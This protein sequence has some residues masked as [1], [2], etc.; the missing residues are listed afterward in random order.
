MEKKG[1]LLLVDCGNSFVFR[2]KPDGTAYLEEAEKNIE[3]LVSPS[4]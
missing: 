1:R 2:I 4:E 3:L